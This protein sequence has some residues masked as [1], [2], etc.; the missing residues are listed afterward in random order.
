M[1]ICCIIPAAGRGTRLNHDRPKVF[2]PIL[3]DKTIFDFL[4]SLVSPHCDGI[5]LVLS[6]DGENYKNLIPVDRRIEI[7]IQ[8]E[9]IGMGDAI[10]KGHE[11]WSKFDYVYI[12]WGDQVNVSQNTMSLMT[13]YAQKKRP[14]I[15]LTRQP[16]PY[17]EYEFDDNNSLYN[18][19]QSREGD[20]CKEGGLSDIGLFGLPVESLKTYWDEYLQNPEMGN[21]TNEVNF[22]PF[23]TFLEKNKYLHFERFIVPDINESKGVNTPEDLLFFQK[24]F[25]ELKA[26]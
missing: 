4:Y 17:V 20:Q 2:V 15:P 6:P 1:K 5:N 26:S 10:F 18:I 25:S 12:I 9:A 19:K 7:S 11:F 3:R 22:L 16:D 13:T 21:Q 14:V 23:L 24:H 8:D